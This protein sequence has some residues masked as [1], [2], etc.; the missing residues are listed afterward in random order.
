VSKFEKGQSGNPG[1]RPKSKELRELCRT[2]TED[3]VKELGRLALRAKGQMTRVVAIREL[4]DRAYG[5]PMHAMEVALED[6]RAPQ[7]EQRQQLAAPEVLEQ[8]GAILAS[9]EKEL[10]IDPVTGLT[11]HQRMQRILESGR[12]LDPV[13]YKAWQMWRQTPET[14]Q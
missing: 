13:L 7:D 4:L 5:R 3:A 14:V 11:D 2:Y 1:G 10:G 6:N 12:P 9:T 8:L